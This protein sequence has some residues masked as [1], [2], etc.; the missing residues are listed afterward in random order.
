MSLKHKRKFHE[1]FVWYSYRIYVS[2]YIRI[3]YVMK[4]IVNTIYGEENYY[5]RFV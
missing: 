2:Q 5:E 1:L 3:M 4:I